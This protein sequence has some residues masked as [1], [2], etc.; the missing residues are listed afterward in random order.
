MKCLC[1][2][3]VCV[4]EE[5]L[6]VS[7]EP[8]TGLWGGLESIRE[9]AVVVVAWRGGVG[10]TVALATWLD[11]DKGIDET[12]TS[13]CRWCDTEAS[14][15][16]IAPITPGCLSGRL[17]AVAAG[18]SDEVNV[19]PAV[20]LEKRSK[21]VDIELFIVV[22]VTRGVRW[23]RGDGEG[24]VVGHV[25]GKTANL[26]GRSR[27]GI[28]LIKQLCSRREVGSPSKPSSVSDRSD[29]N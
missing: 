20:V 4:G 8:G 16:G 7:L 11:P 6:E 12:V 22:G 5:L 10:G 14:A 13:G 21:G 25:G 24:V 1:Q 17:L 18:V 19:S 29:T 15:D 23:S 27:I 9:T 3:W 2:S 28:D 26:R